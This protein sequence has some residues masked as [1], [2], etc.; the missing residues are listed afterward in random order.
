MIGVPS[1]PSGGEDLWDEGPWFD[2]A[3]YASRGG[4]KLAAGLIGLRVDVRGTRCV[5]LGCSTGGFTDCLLQ[6]G[7]ER[8]ISIDTA[9]GELAWTLRQDDRVEVRERTNALHAEVSDGVG[10]AVVDLGWTV[11]RLALPAALAWVGEGGVVLS[12]VKPH[13][14]ATEAG[15]G[16]LVGA[17]GVMAVADAERVLDVVVRRMPEW[18]G[19]V[20]GVVESPISGGKKRARGNAEWVVGVRRSR[21]GGGESVSGPARASAKLPG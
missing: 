20:F 3:R 8:V 2:E 21:L 19:E 15:L 16:R 18:G 6:R 11:Q 7:A 4:V 1:E 12:L 9:Y 14:E 17:K 13:Y 5:D 10:V